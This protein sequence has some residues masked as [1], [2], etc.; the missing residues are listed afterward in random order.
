MQVPQPP[1]IDTSVIPFAG[2]MAAQPRGPF[3]ASGG[4]FV[5]GSGGGGNQTGILERSLAE[6]GGTY[7]DSP[8]ASRGVS[9]DEFFV[10]FAEGTA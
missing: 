9:A 4:V 2:S 7:T 1:E 5:R 10:M 6:G 3:A 8:G